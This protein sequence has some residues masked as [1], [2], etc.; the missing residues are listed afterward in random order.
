VFLDERALVQAVQADIDLGAAPF[1][2]ALPARQQ[3]VLMLPD[4]RRMAG[5]YDLP[6]GVQQDLALNILADAAELARVY[7]ELARRVTAGH[8][9]SES[10]MKWFTGETRAFAVGVIQE[11]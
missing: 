11:G 1:Q 8:E 3:T 10:I 4:F 2:A 6:G 5:D 9:S 7:A